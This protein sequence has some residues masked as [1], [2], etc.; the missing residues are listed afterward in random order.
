[1]K[2]NLICKV[3][4]NCGLRGVPHLGSP[5]MQGAVNIEQDQVSLADDFVCAETS[6]AMSRDS[7]IR[8]KAEAKEAPASREVAITSRDGKYYMLKEG[9][10]EMRSRASYFMSNAEMKKEMITRVH[11]QLVQA[12]WAKLPMLRN[13]R[14]IVN[15]TLLIYS[16]H[17]QETPN[18]HK[19][20]PLKCKPRPSK[21]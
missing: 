6:D 3:R 4:G 15:S 2:C 5:R 13:Q 18:F 1:M 20:H 8:S 19:P 21:H 9:I 12:R 17:I 14:P 11:L 16:I 10:G 7:Q